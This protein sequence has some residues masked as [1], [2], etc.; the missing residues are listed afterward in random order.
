MSPLIQLVYASTMV[1][2]WG[3]TLIG[4]LRSMPGGP[5]LMVFSFSY[6]KIRFSLMF[7][8]FFIMFISECMLIICSCRV[9]LIEMMLYAIQLMFC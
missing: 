5:V 9:G 4:G 8:G 2:D 1:I 6:I 7:G 3:P